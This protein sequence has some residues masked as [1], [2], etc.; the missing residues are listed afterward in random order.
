MEVRVLT[1]EICFDGEAEAINHLFDA[2]LQ[3]LHIRK[4]FA[5][6]SE[7]KELL[8][9]L[10]NQY[11]NRIILHDYHHLTR[12][13]N[14]IGI[15]LNARNPGLPHWFD[16]Q[17]MICTCVCHSL[18]EAKHFHQSA[19][20]AFIS[21]IFKPR[22]KFYDQRSQLTSDE[23]QAIKNALL[24]TVNRIALGGIS[25]QTIQQLPQ[26]YFDGVATLG[27]IWEDFT[28]ADIELPTKRYLQLCQVIKQHQF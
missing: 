26:N 13:F 7:V 14:L 28:S 4:P 25:N 3:W 9:Q 2:G 5:Q 21:P 22:S 8:S 6:E 19:S 16:K 15:H 23:L 1:K 11:Y 12:E 18:Y 24:K 20:A 17:S 27:F 10:D